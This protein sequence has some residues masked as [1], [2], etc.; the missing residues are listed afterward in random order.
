MRIFRRI[1]DPYYE[2]V[3][4]GG[5]VACPQRIMDVEGELVIPVT[6]TR[7]CFEQLIPYCYV[8][9]IPWGLK[10]HLQQAPY[11]GALEIA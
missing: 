4:I 1:K 3:L 5:D 9:R 6:S 11:C 8:L 2:L 10:C 7:R